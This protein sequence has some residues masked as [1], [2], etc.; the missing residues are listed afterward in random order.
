MNINTKK[1]FEEAKKR[2]LEPYQLSFA[3]SVETSVEVFNGEVEQQQIGTSFDIGARA[4]YN[5]KQGSFATDAIDNNTP[6]IMAENIL[7]N[8]RFGK[9]EKAE[10]YFKGGKKYKRAKILFKE[11]KPATLKEVREAALLLCKK[12]QERDPRLTSVQVDISMIESEGNK[13][14]SYG[15]KCKEKSKAFAGYMEVVAENENKE[16]RSGGARFRSF[17]SLE[18]LMKEADKVIDEAI[19][20]AVDFFGT[21]PVPSKKYKAV[22]SYDSFS[23]LFAFFVGQLNA[24]S[25]HKHLSVFEGKLGEQIVSKCLTINHTP[26]VTCFS[27]SSY[28]AE[29]YPTQDFPIIKKG[30]LQ[31]YFYSVETA[32]EEGKESNGCATGAGNGGPVVMTVKKGKYSKEELFAKMKDGLYITSVSG[33]NSGINGQ[34]L[35]FSLPCQGYVI[36]DGKIEKATSMIV[37]AGNLKTL[38]NSIVALGNDTRYSAGTFAPSV[39]V[40][41]I[42]ISGK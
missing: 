18:D 14:N 38:F 33:L 8:A 4:I 36:K 30:V 2:G 6:S 19:H 1:Y 17:L 24:K 40:K 39:L 29:G 25:V 28:D 5:G 12:I 35:D 22:L 21:G 32:L 15:L 27:A 11:F 10:H 7:E 13:M 20:D 23:S 9:E 42:S 34:T 37:M 16:P 41:G 31:T 26:H 3:S